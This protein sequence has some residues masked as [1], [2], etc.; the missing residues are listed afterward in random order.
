MNARIEQ[1]RDRALR[2]RRCQDTEWDPIWNESLA[3]TEGEPEIIRHAKAFAHLFRHRALVIYDHEL[4]VG[5][6]ASVETDPEKPVVPQ[7]FGRQPFRCHWKYATEDMQTWFRE[8]MLS[9]AG[10]HTT[11]DY[12]QVLAI[13]FEGLIDH[14]RAR[15]AR[16]SPG[17]QDYE[18]KR[19]FLEGLEIV[20]AGYIDF[21]RRYAPYARALARETV[22]PVRRAELDTIARACEQVPGKPPRSF[23]EACQALWFCFYF[24]PDA[25]GRV[26][27]YLAPFYRAD[28]ESGRIDEERARELLSCLWIKYFEIAGAAAGV[29]AHQHLTLGGVKPDGA[30]ASNDVTRLCLDVTEDLRLHRPQVGFRWNPNTPPRACWN[31]P[32]ACS[33]RT[34]ATPISATTSR[35]SP[36]SSRRAWRSRTRAISPSP[37]ATR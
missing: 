35:S 29:S 18:Q 36:R 25:P 37:A 24:L 20:A 22:D 9:P 12:E 32:C 10:N 16:L 6:P 30:D 26:D 5:A 4:I 2:S 19:L 8:G 13:G 15:K 28:I 33:G 14:V 7:I 3:A 34:P 31:G 1:I 17:E 11:M 27:Q 23:H 21:C